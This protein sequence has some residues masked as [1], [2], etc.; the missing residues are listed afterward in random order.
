M[1]DHIDEIEYDEDTLKLKQLFY[2]R[3]DA[4]TTATQTIVDMIGPTVLE[5]MYEL[6]QVPVEQV[7]WLDF[8]STDNLLIVVCAIQYNPSKGTP[9]FIQNVQSNRTEHNGLVSQTFRLGVPFEVVLSTS[10]NVLNFLTALVASHKNGGPTLIQEMMSDVEE[11]DKKPQH[12][13]PS[14]V[15]LTPLQTQQLLMF[16]HQTKGKVH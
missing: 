14:P 3:D 9:Q 7:K 8:Q 4:Y 2:D 11:Q 10:E 15:K 6:F 16:Q 12:D 1:D 5:A 13:E